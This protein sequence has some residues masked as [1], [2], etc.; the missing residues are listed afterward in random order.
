MRKH[1]FVR[2]L[3]CT[4]LLRVLVESGGVVD[5]KAETYNVRWTYDV[6]GDKTIR[7]A[8]ALDNEG[9]V[10]F[11]AEDSY[12]YKLDP[13]GAFKWR[14]YLTEVTYN[15]ASPSI[16]P[17]NTIYFLSDYYLHAINPDGTKK[18][19]FR[20]DS[21]NDSSTAVGP[22]GV[23]YFG[24]SKTF[25]AINPDGTEKRIRTLLM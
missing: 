3:L 8:P 16:G 12:L 4:L 23:V 21:T 1:I 6:G 19:Q 22:D 11:A 24:D 5:V 15:P 10:Y 13:D 20:T 25:Y 2:L 18:W 7:G 14:Y 9:N 17:D